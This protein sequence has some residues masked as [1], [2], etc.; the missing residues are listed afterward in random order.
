MTDIEGTL[1]G[2]AYTLTITTDDD[3]AT[4]LDDMI[5][6]GRESEDEPLR[7]PA[8][9]DLDTNTVV[10][11]NPTLK[12]AEELVYWVNDTI[13]LANNPRYG[14]VADPKAFFTVKYEHIEFGDGVCECTVCQ[15][16]FLTAEDFAP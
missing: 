8:M 4:F 13:N 1:K 7:P 10:W 12:D 11:L 5:G 16:G 6:R 2:V 9:V 14:P 15:E 3:T